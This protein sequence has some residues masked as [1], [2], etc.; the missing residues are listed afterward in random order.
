VEAGELLGI[1]VLDHIIIGNLDYVS[2]KR[3]GLF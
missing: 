3:K 1:E 2:M